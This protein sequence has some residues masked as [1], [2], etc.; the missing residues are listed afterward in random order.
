[1]R[2]MATERASPCCIHVMPGSHPT[3]FPATAPQRCRAPTPAALQGVTFRIDY[4]VEAIGNKEFGSVFLQTSAGQQENVAL[5]IV[6]NGWAKVRAAGG[7]GGGTHAGDAS[8]GR[9]GIPTPLQ[10][11]QHGGWHFVQEICM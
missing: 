7:G 1:M 5:S 6:Q 10:P 11:C 8:A 3:T 4:V 2:T 9:S